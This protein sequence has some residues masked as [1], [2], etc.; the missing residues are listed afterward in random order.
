VVADFLTALGI[1][2]LLFVTA[3]AV[4]LALMLRTMM[5]ANRV[6]P[7]RRTA[8]P[9][10]WLASPRTSAR[11]H[12]RL[13][14]AVSVSDFAVASIAPAAIALRGVAGELTERAVTVDDW[15][16]GTYRLHPDA[17]RPRLAQLSAEVRGIEMSAAR[18]HHLSCDWRRC[19][20]QAAASAALPL[21]D[22]HQRLD[23]VEAALRDLPTMPPGQAATVNLSR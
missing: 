11:L 21:P 1:V 15:L 2:A 7:K 5:R 9:L 4:G 6:A 13:R 3:V 19:L 17:R 20:D 12:R 14:R 16:V 23:A 10:S 22:L 18:L 8:A